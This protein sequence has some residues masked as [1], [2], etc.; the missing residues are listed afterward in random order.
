MMPAR[1]ILLVALPV[2]TDIAIPARFLARPQLLT[3]VSPLPG[4]RDISRTSPLW[5]L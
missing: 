5:C 3:R 2:L 1:F 4:G